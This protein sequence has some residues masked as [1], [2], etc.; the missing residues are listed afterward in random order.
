[1]MKPVAFAAAL[2]AASATTYLKESFDEAAWK[3]KWVVGSEWK[4][5]SE[6][7]EWGWT[8]GKYPGKSGDKAIQTSQ[9]ARFYSV[10]APLDATFDNAGKDLVISYTV[11][12]E[13][14]LDCGG[15]YIKLT[16]KI[17]NPKKFGGD[18]KYGIMF[19]PD[20]CGYSTRR[21]H[22]ILTDKAGKNHL[23]KK[24]ITPETDRLSHRYTL[25][26]RPDNTYEVQID[27]NKKESGNIVDDWDML[28]AKMIKDPS[29]KKPS[30][31]VDEERIPDPEDVKPAGWDDIPAK[32]VDP[33]AKKPEDWNDEEDGEWTAPTID[34]PEYKGEWKPKMV[35]NPAYKGVWVHPEIE[36]PDYHAEDAKSLY[37]VCNPCEAVGFE[38]WQVKSGTMFDD[39]IVTDSLAEADAFAKETFEAKKAAEKAAFDAIEAAKKEEEDRKRKEEEEKRKA[40]EA[41]KKKADDEDDDEDDEDKS[42]L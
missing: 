23:I 12:H 37:H 7:G 4:S 9:D 36:N 20:V 26:L 21:T 13:Q 30:D 25:I 6:M 28:P 2:G 34:N 42:E 38:L 16:P 29:A 32:I 35:P 11:K 27:G 19:G 40:E 18:D 5:A 39:I 41:S 8:G 1:M 17:K 22:V 14:D 3:S 31:W 10:S 24:T 33:A 15:A